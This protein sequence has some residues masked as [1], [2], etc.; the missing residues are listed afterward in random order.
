MKYFSIFYNTL[1]NKGK[2]SSPCKIFSQV[3]YVPH[4]HHKMVY[5]GE[6]KNTL[7]NVNKSNFEK[8]K[9]YSITSRTGDWD[10]NAE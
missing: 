9:E 7:P 4:F 10:S 3:N 6:K 8:H 1:E 5:S 2:I